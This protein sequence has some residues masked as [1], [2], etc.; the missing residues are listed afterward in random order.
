MRAFIAIVLLFMFSCLYAGAQNR[1]GRFFVDSVLK[2]LPKISSDT[3]KLDAYGSLISQYNDINLDTSLY[4]AY[5]LMAHAR[6][7]DWDRG[8]L[9]AYNYVGFVHYLQSHF[10]S[11]KYYYDKCIAGYTK[12]KDTL[13]LAGCY[14]SMADVYGA[15]NQLS[16]SLEYYFRA[17]VAYQSI[18]E[19][20]IA[21]LYSDIGDLYGL[22]GEPE[23]ANTYYEKALE[24]NSRYGDRFDRA[25]IMM[26]LVESLIEDSE[27][28]EAIKYAD[29]VIQ[30]YTEFGNKFF[31]AAGENYLAECYYNKGNYSKAQRLFRISGDYF[32]HASD[33]QYVAYNNVSLGK[34]YLAVA[35]DTT[36]YKAD[37]SLFEPTREQNY[38]KAIELLNNA[39]VF[40]EGI[41]EQT[42]LID[43]YGYLSDAYEGIGEP[44]TALALYKQRSALKDSLDIQNESKKV[45]K[46]DARK[47]I[48]LKDKELELQ[49]VLIAKKKNERLALIAG[50]AVLFIVLVIIFRNYRERGKANKLLS[51][52][53][54]K[55]EE[56]LLNI[57][58]EEVAEE[59]KNR[60]ATTA[61]QYDRVTVLFTDFVDFTVAG[62][63]MGSQAL[64]EELHNCFKAFDGI[65]DKYG[66]EKIKTIGDAYL[67]VCGLPTADEYHA[68]KVVQAAQEIR[69]FMV[70]RREQLG[71]KTF[72]VRIG[73][74][75][76]SVVAGIVGVKKFAYDIWG[77]TVN[78]AA[79]MESH[80]EAGKIN[81][82]QTTYELVKDKF[83]C[84]YRGE[85]EAKGKGQ[86]K[87]YF[88]EG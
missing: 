85:I 59:L 64:V 80:S 72:E 49:H 54:Q 11:A 24:A 74:H 52:E 65:M 78:T 47:A 88:V 15:S 31:I 7:M 23:K 83:S 79:R 67:A 53:K 16:V 20:N 45:A 2:E 44:A 39:R 86:L 32:S 38:Q 35:A 41:N 13:E 12:L 10:D 56:L 48:E 82:S 75:S 76:G 55:S 9:F 87:M 46:L 25:Y 57:L 81:V 50:I 62:E 42:T 66:I 84:T 6:K 5:K 14:H 61:Q 60:G 71:N 33:K 36:G 26:S 8:D 43:I 63:H 27:Y 3:D 17:L 68:E 34:T 19:E 73:V 77:D 51:E 18:G 30:I 29:S 22:A 69:N 28:D 37:T 1:G 70:Q 58:P 4:Y 21:T 40:F